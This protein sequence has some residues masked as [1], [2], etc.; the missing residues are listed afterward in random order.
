LGGKKNRK[1]SVEP[2]RGKSILKFSRGK[3]GNEDQRIEV[4]I[5]GATCNEKKGAKT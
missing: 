1:T 4:L 3:R 5:K 2:R